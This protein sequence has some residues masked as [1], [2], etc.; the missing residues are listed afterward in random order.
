[1]GCG[2]DTAFPLGGREGR[3][4]WSEPYRLEGQAAAGSCHLP[5]AR[6]PR[7]S[8]RLLGGSWPP[9]SELPGVW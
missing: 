4:T 7:A 1:M 2:W 8:P 6:G 9:A 5:E 3:A